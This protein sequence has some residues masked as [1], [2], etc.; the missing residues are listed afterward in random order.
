MPNADTIFLSPLRY[1][2]GKARLAAFVAGLIA[3]QRPRPLR[4]V[5]P[6][7]G[8][9]GVALR[10]LF[11]ERVDEIVINDLNPGLAAFWRVLYDQPETLAE[12][13]LES[14]AT[15][16]E[17]HQQRALYLEQPDDDLALGFATFFLNRTNRSGIL[18][19]R[20]IGGLEQTG[21]WKI[22]A[23]Y[24]PG[25]LA[26]RIELLARYASRVTVTQ[27]DG[28]DLID[29]VV[30]DTNTF[31]YADP[32]YLLQ[33]DELYMDTFE[34]GHHQRLAEVLRPGGN[35]FLTYD[36]DPRVLELYRGLRYASFDI[37]HSAARQHFGKEY[38]VFSPDLQVPTLNGLGRT[39]EA[40]T[41]G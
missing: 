21:K 9:A 15:I 41:V 4:Y 13:V 14:S 39:H 10:L 11:D 29:G 38:A 5:E 8:G 16:E 23:R 28:V 18:G 6:F 7:A 35:W 31:V 27:L 22:D 33:G 30:A 26:E 37:A 2:G 32:P 36:A 12:R 25:K 20:P 3:A 19:A 34:W 40:L 17:W 1:P 24:S